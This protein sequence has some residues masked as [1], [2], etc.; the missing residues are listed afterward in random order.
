MAGIFITGTDTGIGKTHVSVQILEACRKRGV[1]TSVMKP[2]ASGAELTAAGL[3]NE[4][5]VRLMA[6]ATASQS[7]DEVNPYAFA[8]AIAPH[9]AAAEAGVEIDPAHLQRCNQLNQ[10]RADLCLVEGVGGWC[11]PLSDD[12]MLSDL[13][14]ALDLPVIMVVGIRLGCLN[15]AL[16]TAEKVLADGCQLAGWIANHVDPQMAHA[17]DNVST[18][19]RLIPAPML[20]ELPF[21]PANKGTA[22]AAESDLSALLDEFLLI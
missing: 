16:L 20:A 1:S 17:S 6:A 13:V 4:D 18:L 5:A 7:Y 15:H 3:R 19:Q 14:K 21:T 10:Q 12:L 22:V 2:V 8:P 9:L 11:V